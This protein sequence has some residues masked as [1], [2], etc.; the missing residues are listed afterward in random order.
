MLQANHSLLA[1]NT[2]GIN[3]NARWWMEVHSAKGATEFIMDNIG[4]KQQY[5]VL[6]GGSNLLFVADFPGIVLKNSIMGRE[7][8]KETADHLWLKVGAGENWHELVLFCLEND[9]GGIENLSLIPGCVGAAPIQNIG[10]YGVEIKD[11]FDS[12]EAIHLETATPRTFDK[13]ACRFGYRDSYFKQEGKGK[14]IITSVILRLSKRHHSLHTSYGAIQ[15]ELAKHSGEPNIQSVSRAVIAIRQR[16]LPDP[17]EIGNAGSFFKNPIVSADA[18]ATLQERFPDIPH[19]PE[20]DGRIK[21]PAAWLIQTAGWKGKRFGN[22]GV[23]DRQ[24]LV[25]VNHG[26][27]SGADLFRLSE[28]IQQS[29][30]Q[31]FSVSLERE[32]NVV[33]NR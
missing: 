11:V 22:Y 9:W 32:V 16:K 27:A 10:A 29:V 3:A 23:H 13:A 18:F 1:H 5:L 17:S 14:Y 6:G 12:L 8:I 19:Y 28:E 30:R 15:E 26:G 4:A 24:A 25:L 21:L 7:V 2:F 31:A 33:G 20:S